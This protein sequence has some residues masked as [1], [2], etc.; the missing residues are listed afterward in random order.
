MASETAESDINYFFHTSSRTFCPPYAHGSVQ[1]GKMYLFVG[2]FMAL[3]QG[4][5]VRRIKSG[6]ESLYALIVSYAT[7]T[8]STSTSATTSTTTAC[9]AAC[10]TRAT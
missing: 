8:T 4:G 1:Q 5:F 3:L 7:T 10:A 6:K 9:S 2:I